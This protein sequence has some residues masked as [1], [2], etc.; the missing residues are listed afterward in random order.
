[1]I[2][3]YKGEINLIISTDAEKACEKNQYLCMI[4]LLSK[5]GSE[6]NFLNIKCVRERKPIAYLTAGSDLLIIFSL[7][8]WMK[9]EAITSIQHWG[10]Q[11]NKAR[12]RN[13]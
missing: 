3:Q 7:T 6:G 13:S 4:K 10:G 5:V 12:K 8:S 9:K 1:M 11:W 2:K